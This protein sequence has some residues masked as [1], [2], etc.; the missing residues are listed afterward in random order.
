LRRHTPR[1]AHTEPTAITSQIELSNNSTRIG[2]YYTTNRFAT[3][4]IKASPKDSISCEEF[5]RKASSLN[6]A[7]MQSVFLEISLVILFRFIKRPRCHN[8]GH[9]WPFESS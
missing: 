4:L 7:S 3:R 2:I 5:S 6:S 1:H 9:N 8:L